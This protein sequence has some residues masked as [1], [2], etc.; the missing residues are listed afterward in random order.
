MRNL[1]I[2]VCQQKVWKSGRKEE[3]DKKEQEKKEEEKEEE[4]ESM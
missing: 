1:S 4:N 3:E 2:E